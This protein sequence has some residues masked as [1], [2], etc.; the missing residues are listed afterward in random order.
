MKQNHYNSMSNLF[1]SS[2]RPYETNLVYLP[3]AYAVMQCST[4]SG[5]R[6]IP[7]IRHN[8]KWANSSMSYGTTTGMDRKRVRMPRS[9]NW[10]HNHHLPYRTGHGRNH[11]RHAPLPRRSNSINL[12]SKLLLHAIRA[13]YVTW[14]QYV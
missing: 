1:S 9:F 6:L 8:G 7:P 5:W 4:R 2:E 14:K 12:T 10:R 13:I 3:C 11:K